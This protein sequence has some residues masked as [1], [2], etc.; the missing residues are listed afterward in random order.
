MKP[1]FDNGILY[2]K[3]YD[4]VNYQDNKSEL[5]YRCAKANLNTAGSTM[6]YSA[7][8]SPIDAI[9]LIR[10]DMEQEKA[11]TASLYNSTQE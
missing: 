3:N 9:T 11:V 4:P 10:R 8:Y 5:T 7:N 6:N 2:Y 1:V